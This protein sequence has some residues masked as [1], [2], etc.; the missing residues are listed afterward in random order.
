MKKRFIIYAIAFAA[1]ALGTV[2]CKKSELK[3]P[4]DISVQMDINRQVSPQGHLVFDSGY[5][6]LANF[7]AEGIR[8]EGAP[9]EMSKTF[10]TGLIVN[11]SPTDF[12]TELYLDIPQG[13]YTNLDIEFETYEGIDQPTIQVTGTYTN[14]SSQT[15]PVIFE[16]GSSETFIIDAESETGDPVITLDKNIPSTAFI[17]FDPQY[18]FDIVSTNMWD[19]A[20]LVDVQGTMTILIND[21]ENGAIYDLIADRID[22]ATEATFGN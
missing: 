7:A 18:W 12:I 1:Y 8:Q 4:A 17:Q 22:D 11:F 9:V 15:F 6:R 3:K 20:S 14:Q 10:S 21:S 13:N 5:I 19:N 2:S 16:F